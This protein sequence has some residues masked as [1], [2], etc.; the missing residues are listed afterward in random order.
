MT[1]EIN[2]K[3][4]TIDEKSPYLS[5]VIDLWSP[6]RSTLGFLPKDAFKEKAAKK[7]IIVAIAEQN[8]CIG[9][10]LYNSSYSHD[11]VTI[12]HLCI[13]NS[14]RRKGVAKLLVD[15][16]KKITRKKFRGIGLHC[17]RD[18]GLAGLWSSLGFIS[19]YDIAGKS[20]DG[21][22]LTYWWFDYGHPDL[23]SSIP[24]KTLESKLCVVVDKEVFFDLYADEDIDTSETSIP[25]QNTESKLLLSDWLQAEL[26]L[27][28]TDAIFNQINNISDDEERKVQRKL[29]ENNFTLLSCK[30]ENLDIIQNQL[31]KFIAKTN[32]TKS[33]IDINHIARTIASESHIFVTREQELLDVT[34]EIYENFRLSVLQPSELLNQL[35]ELRRNPNYQPIRLAGTSLEQFPIERGQEDS[36]TNDFYCSKKGETKAGFQQQLRRF[37]TNPDKFDCFIVTGGENQKLALFIYGRHKKHELEI[38]MFRVADNLLS[39]TLAQHLIF[40]SILTSSGEGRKFT[41]IT[42]SYLQDMVFQ[43]IQEYNFVRVDNGFL[44]IHLAIAKTASQLSLTLNKIASELGEDYNFCFKL[45]NSLN[46]DN[47]TKNIQASANLE[48]LLFPAK[49]I[50]AE[51]PNFIIPIQPRWAKDLFDEGLAN[52]NLPLFGTQNELAFNRE[53]VY[54]KSAKNSARIKSYSRIFWYVSQDKY[55]DYIRVGGIRACSL[56]DE[57]IIGK[58]RE[59]YQRFQRLGIYKF[60]DISNIKPDNNGN[61]MAIR[62]CNTE[63]LKF[64]DYRKI[65]KILNTGFT[66]QSP[67]KINSTDFEKLYNIGTD[68]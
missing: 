68:N 35:N 46:E 17:R 13:N 42:D 61:I 19:K 10:L 18:Y 16:L 38:P 65:Q 23:I 37:L 44:K 49:I 1:E 55:S 15:R 21:K 25:M 5:T 43:A 24:Q 58:P 4:Q 57:V 11:R 28:I 39:A 30:S 7:Q 22:L 48:R 9:Y 54:Y 3:I 36:F 33:N 6:N 40:K 41:R 27:C 59:L 31:E 66:F 14:Y 52:Q 50:D 53:A 45:A 8:N 51:I 47:L 64:I 32:I 29:A 56:V 67:Y 34:D 20:K 26:E 60:S 62:F 2:F 12:V 63:L